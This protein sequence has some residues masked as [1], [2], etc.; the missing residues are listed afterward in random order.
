MLVIKGVHSKI[1]IGNQITQHIPLVHKL[2][3]EQCLHAQ[4][5]INAITIVVVDVINDNTWTVY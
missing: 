2:L 5:I 3:H 4:P 1:P